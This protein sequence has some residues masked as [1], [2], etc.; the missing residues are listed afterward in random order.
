MR[1]LISIN[2]SCYNRSRMLRECLESFITQTFRDFEII[3]VDD[4]STE[5]LS[6]VAKLD[7][8]I[9]YFK[10]EHSGMARGLNLAYE[11]SSGLY[12]LPFGSDDLAL[13][14]LLEELIKQLNAFS[15][16]DVIYPDCW[17]QNKDG[18][19]TRNKL[20]EYDSPQEAYMAML[21]KQFIPHGGTLWRKD[22][23]PKY[24]ETVGSAEDWEFFL[25]AMEAGLLFKHIDKR[26]WVYRVGH[27]RE[28]KHDSQNNG[29]EKVLNRR[30]YTFDLK[31]REGKLCNLEQ[32]K[33]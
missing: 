25:G 12:V 30:G 24:D 5:D 1:P 6:F 23:Y 17:V 4:G 29:C 8:R 33:Q 16:Y 28:S 9:S 18:G 15:E 3:V 11:K 27:P 19:R 10:Q 22:K 7:K 14:E 32:V 21:K 2:I 13:P 20:P 31:K 26:L